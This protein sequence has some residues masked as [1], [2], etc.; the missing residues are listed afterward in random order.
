MKRSRNQKQK[1][2]SIPASL[3]T[4]W[5]AGCFVTILIAGMITC[6]ISGEYVQET[7]L[8]PISCVTMA[9]S[10]LAASCITTKRA[11]KFILP[12]SLASGVVHYITLV[13]CNALFFN[14]SYRGLGIGALNILISVS[15]MSIILL[16]NTSK[17]TVHYKGSIRP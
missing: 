8:A 3:L 5:L 9:L 12:M 6:L 4:G 2:H 16:R 11:G 15:I 1:N 7:Y 14:A 17:K 10:A 13:I